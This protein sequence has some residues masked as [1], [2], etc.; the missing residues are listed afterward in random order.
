MSETT[1][2][3]SDKHKNKRQ[4]RQTSESAI[5]GTN[6]FTLE[7]HRKRQTSEQFHPRTT[8][9]EKIYTNMKNIKIILGRITWPSC[10]SSY[11]RTAS[12]LTGSSQ[13]SLT[14][15]SR[16]S[17]APGRDFLQ[18]LALVTHFRCGCCRESWLI[19][20]I[21]LFHEHDLGAID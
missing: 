20:Y 18:S 16:A 10:S 2:I 15:H 6:N 5:I 21:N 7:R 9:M 1:I 13:D 19:N 8:C 12:R 3:R 14:T 4:K 17:R 11:W